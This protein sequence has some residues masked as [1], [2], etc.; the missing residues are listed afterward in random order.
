MIIAYVPEFGIKE[1][2]VAY[3]C[4]K[5]YVPPSAHVQLGFTVNCCLSEEYPIE[6]IR[7]SLK[8]ILHNIFLIGSLLFVILL[9][10]R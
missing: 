7:E 1:Y 6:D 3:A 8:S 9:V 5:V 2:Y 4:E 10:R